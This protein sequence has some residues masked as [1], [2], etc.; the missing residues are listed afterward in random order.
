[1]FKL[2]KTFV[3]VDAFYYEDKIKVK[4]FALDRQVFLKS[5]RPVNHS[6]KP[7]QNLFPTTLA[8]LPKR[9][10]SKRIAMLYI[11]SN[12]TGFNRFR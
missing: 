6:N 8:I 3:Q 9:W 4:I 11:I 10:P 12:V 2:Q 7:L 5:I 1:M